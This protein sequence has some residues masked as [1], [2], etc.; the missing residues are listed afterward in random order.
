LTDFKWYYD[1]DPDRLSEEKNFMAYLDY[2]FGDADKGL[3]KGV[4]DSCHQKKIVV[5]NNSLPIK[6]TFRVK[7]IFDT[8]STYHYHHRM[9]VSSGRN[10]N[11]MKMFR[12][13]LDSIESDF[14]DDYYKEY[15]NE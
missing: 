11:F 7:E 6:K 5:I 3:G 14:C 9:F 12:E 2:F 13:T 4:R 10:K 1:N 15:Y 8:G